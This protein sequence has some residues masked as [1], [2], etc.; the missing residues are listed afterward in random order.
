MKNRSDNK[1]K[2]EKVKKKQKSSLCYEYILSVIGTFAICLSMR[3][4]VYKDMAMVQLQL[5]NDEMSFQPNAFINGSGSQTSAK[6]ENYLLAH[7]NDRVFL[8]SKMDLNWD[9]FANFT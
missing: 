4:G 2:Q 9:D 5:V 1:V 6:G 3:T 7:H 8:F